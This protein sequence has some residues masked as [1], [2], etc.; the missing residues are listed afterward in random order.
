MKPL[1]YGMK[2]IKTWLMNV[3]ENGDGIILKK[4]E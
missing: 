2:I 4:I 3:Q 1:I